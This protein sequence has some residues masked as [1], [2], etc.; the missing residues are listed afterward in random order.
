MVLSADQCMS[1]S[2][3]ISGSYTPVPSQS[4][5][6]SFAKNLKRIV[7]RQNSSVRDILIPWSVCMDLLYACILEFLAVTRHYHAFGIL[8]QLQRSLKFRI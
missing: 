3:K 4:G 2:K 6:T 1:Y 5:K 7:Y 8:L